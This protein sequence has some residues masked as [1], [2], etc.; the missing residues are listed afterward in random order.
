MDTGSASAELQRSLRIGPHSLG[1][2]SKLEFVNV[3]SWPVVGTGP[4]RSLKETLNLERKCRL[5]SEDG[6]VLVRWLLD[7]SSSSKFVRLQ[8]DW[9]ISPC[10]ILKLKF[11]ERSPFKRP[12]SGEI[13]PVKPLF[14]RLSTFGK[15]L[16]LR[17]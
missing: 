4:S 6:I 16:V 12:I 1:L 7:K 3:L 15:A 9:G 8:I 17:N 11:S 2:P 10:N 5:F 13:T 14:P